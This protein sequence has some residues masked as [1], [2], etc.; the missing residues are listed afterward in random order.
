MT[1]KKNADEKQQSAERAAVEEAKDQ[2]D[3]AEGNVA[4]ADADFQNRSSGLVHGDVTSSNSQ[5]NVQGQHG[6]DG[7]VVD[8]RDANPSPSDEA[9]ENANENRDGGDTNMAEEENKEEGPKT[10]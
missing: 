1:E 6:R 5:Q 3:V 2:P 9:I 8:G 10:L 4:G 7:G